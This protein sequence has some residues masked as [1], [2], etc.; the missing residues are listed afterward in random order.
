VC[1][2]SCDHTSS[3]LCYPI[4]PFCLRPSRNQLKIPIVMT[5]KMTTYGTLPHRLVNS[6]DVSK[7]SNASIFMIQAAPPH[8]KYCLTHF[9]RICYKCHSKDLG[10]VPAPLN[11]R[12]PV[13]HS[14][15]PP[16]EIPIFRQVS[17]FFRNDR[18]AQKVTTGT[19][20]ELVAYYMASINASSSTSE[21]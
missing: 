1:Q 16:K 5:R 18:D 19:E 13:S 20:S 8:K 9:T 6:S 7:K 21:F 14:N 15:R 17:L 2:P 11:E 10:N 12:C 3:N 4:P